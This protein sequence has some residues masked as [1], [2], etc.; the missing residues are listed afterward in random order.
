MFL[1]YNARISLVLSHFENMSMKYT[2]IFKVA[3]IENFQI[4]FLYN[5]DL[6]FLFL[7]KTTA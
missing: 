4:F 7:L 3:K 6:Y 2:E 5:I 1:V